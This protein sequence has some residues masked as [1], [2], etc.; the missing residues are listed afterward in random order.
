LSSLRT[1]DY[2]LRRLIMPSTAELMREIHRL[3]KFAR[4]LKEQMDR[5]P[6]QL[7]AQRAKVARLEEAANSNQEA[8]K[9]LK[10]ALHEKE[11][12]LKTTHNQIAKHQK[13]LNEA[14]AKKE[15]DAL[16][17][18]IASARAKCSQLEEESLA[19]M[20]ESEERAAKIPE[21]EKAAKAAKEAFAQYEKE[22]DARL[23]SLKQQMEEAQAKTK[24]VE[25]NVPKNVRASFDRIVKGQGADAFAPVMD[26]GC[27]A[28]RT[29]IIAQQYNELLMGA[30]VV[31]KMCGRILYLPEQAATGGEEAE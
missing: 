18:E 13:Q 14:G 8:I 27:G 23:T 20:G 5:V 31:C 22:S 3:R 21:L 15:Y 16:Q 29:E 24:E 28:C 4:D 12:T 2:G 6:L 1:M 10:I 26:R 30:F 9:K 19:A 25:A 11:V 7:K 17:T